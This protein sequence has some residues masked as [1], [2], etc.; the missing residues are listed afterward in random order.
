[1]KTFDAFGNLLF[2]VLRVLAWVLGLVGLVVAG[3]AGIEAAW[4][5]FRAAGL[6]ALPVIAP[7]VAVWLTTRLG[8]R[9]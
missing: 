1:M 9:R 8:V 6:M 2:G 5:F 4:P 3:T 7:H